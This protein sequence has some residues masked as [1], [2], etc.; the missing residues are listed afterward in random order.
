MRAN[1]ETRRRLSLASH[2]IIRKAETE[3]KKW[4]GE[5]EEK[6][7]KKEGGGEIREQKGEKE[8]RKRGGGGLPW[9]YFNLNLVV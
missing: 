9:R 2:C 3:R 5:G 7:R 1:F 6:E 8:E 4:G